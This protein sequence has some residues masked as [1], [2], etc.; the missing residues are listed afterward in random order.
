MEKGRK[1][2]LLD[3]TAAGTSTVGQRQ[4]AWLRRTIDGKDAAWRPVKYNR[5]SAQRWIYTLERQLQTSSDKGGLLYF[6]YDAKN[7]NFADWRRWPYL[8][9]ASDLGSDGVCGWHA[10][11]WGFDINTVLYPDPSHGCQ[12]TM[13][14]ALKQG[15]V[16][17]F[18]LLC[19]IT[20]NL[21]FGPWQEE[22][23]R[24]ELSSAM[25]QVYKNFQPHECPLF[26]EMASKMVQE[27]EDH[28]IV[29]FARERPIEVE[30]WDFL[31]NRTR[32]P[33]SG[34]RTAMN[35]FGGAYHAAKR[36]LPWWSVMQWERTYL[37][38]EQGMLSGK[39]FKE[40]LKKAASSA[41][42]SSLPN[43]STDGRRLQ[44]D[45]RTLRKCCS[46]AV[47]MSVLT[48]QEQQHKRTIQLIVAAGA[49]L[50]RWH[51]DQNRT[52][53]SAVATSQWLKEQTA[54][55]FMEHVVEFVKLLSDQTV[56]TSAGFNLS[57]AI[58]KKS[59]AEAELE[60]LIED[61]Y[62]DLLGLLCMGF[63]RQRLVRGLHLLAW[64][65]QMLACRQ[66]G[67]KAVAVVE[68]FRRDERAFLALEAKPPTT[69]QERHIAGRHVMQLRATKQYRVAFR[70]A[71]YVAGPDFL[72]LLEDQSMI[73]VQTQVIEDMN[74]EQKNNSALKACRRF[75]KPATCM[76][77][78]L[79]ADVI[80]TR[81]SFLN[82]QVDD[83]VPLTSAKIPNE[84]F[85]PCDKNSSSVDFSSVVSTDASAP[86]WSP[87]AG[88]MN[89]PAADVP[90]VVEASERD[91]WDVINRA[92]V[93]EVGDLKHRLVVRL[94][95]LGSAGHTWYLAMHSF[96]KS[97]VLLWPVEKR[98]LEGG[99]VNF[100]LLT[101]V[102]EPKL[103]PLY[104]LGEGTLAASVKW[105][106]PVWQF[107]HC[108]ATRALPPAV[109]LFQDGPADKLENI[110]SRAAWWNL[111]RSTLAHFAKDLGIAT[112]S[113]PSE[114][115]LVWA[116]AEGTLKTTHAQTLDICH[117]R[118]ARGN[119]NEAVMDAILEV[120]EAVQVLDRHDFERVKDAKK[121]TEYVRANVTE[122]KSHYSTKAS[123]VAADG[124][125]AKR[126]K[127]LLKKFVL[128]HHISQA[129][130][131][132]FLPPATS[133]WRDLARGGW[134]GHCPPNSRLSESFDKHAGSSDDAFRA[135]LV[136]L[137]IQN[138]E[139]VGQP[140]ANICTVEG[141]FAPPPA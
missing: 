58:I 5:T 59:V 108:L 8:T 49:P 18:W 41:T 137:W 90:M 92:W 128:P 78:G 36:C 9:I 134:C 35:R 126:A 95:D 103:R 114:F 50:D 112:E 10:L 13:E 60:E 113:A 117:R 133:V 54:G 3:H 32:N 102:S 68:A 28:H 55:G 136:R 11:A 135:L 80:G 111:P 16:W 39:L 7:R 40:K 1:R 12:R 17:E 116:L 22:G 104:T 69:A 85:S 93:G 25:G 140:P 64:P 121:H 86:W 124:P 42:S 20:W 29:T 63:V 138:A 109:R 120:D 100:H 83:P 87:P 82:V 125:K 131:K 91:D 88:N 123:K 48:L 98:I 66:G 79:Q 62:S 71:G 46:N 26:Q 97:S 19:M 84:A 38:I 99:V 56:L 65:L 89:A 107:R 130:A 33:V 105:R 61:E 74:G 24:T 101:E 31:A 23:R 122:F 77:V 81:H 96:P 94:P 75:R 15:G 37:A 139:K 118:V 47:A 4:L 115:D 30:L 44:L 72:K 70:D 51:T 27:L 2:K 45:D 106:S 6:Q 52:L 129:D 110:A 14:N 21:E 132:R 67:A 43:E 73:N 53:R 127:A 119:D 141:L 76:A 57:K 34:R